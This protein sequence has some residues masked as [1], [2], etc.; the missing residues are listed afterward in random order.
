MT[1]LVQLSAV[2]LK[3]LSRILDVQLHDAEAVSMTGH[4]STI[5]ENAEVKH[6]W[7]FG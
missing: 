4:N 7:V 6:R 2:P 3:Y 5:A 1:M